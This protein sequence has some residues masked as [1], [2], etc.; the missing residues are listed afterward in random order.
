MRQPCFSPSFYREL[1]SENP[2]GLTLNWREVEAWF[3]FIAWPSYKT[4][5]YRKHTVAVRRWWAR[6][7]LSELQRA[8]EAL[9]NE[10]LEIAQREQDALSIV[11]ESTPEIDPVVLRI[12]GGNGVSV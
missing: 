7:K 12:F 6:A 3:R 1:A 8:R 4:Y 10:K 9:E 2:F 5:R 11:I